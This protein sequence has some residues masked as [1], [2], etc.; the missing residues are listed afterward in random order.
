MGQSSRL[1]HRL[2]Q[3]FLWISGHEA[4]INSEE[5]KSRN[6]AAEKESRQT[7]KKAAELL[8]QFSGLPRFGKH[9]LIFCSVYQ[10][11]L[12][13]AIN[14]VPQSTDVC[15]EAGSCSIAS[16]AAGG[17]VRCEVRAT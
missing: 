10:N 6:L 5:K 14:Q 12:R 7:A 11:G 1:A 17:E 16:V 13:N 4:K 8:Q 9:S 15:A 2:L 3:F